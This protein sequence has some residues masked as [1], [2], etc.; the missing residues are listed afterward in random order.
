MTFYDF[1]N[2]TNSSTY[3]AYQSSD[4]VIYGIKKYEACQYTI[5]TEKVCKNDLKVKVKI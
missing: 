4:N 2:L 3:L 1:V 5:T